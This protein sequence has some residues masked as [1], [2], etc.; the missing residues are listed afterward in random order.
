MEIDNDKDDKGFPQFCSNLFFFRSSYINKINW[1]VTKWYI[2]KYDKKYERKTGTIKMGDVK[3]LPTNTKRNLCYPLSSI[4]SISY[5]SIQ[6]YV[7]ESIHSA[8]K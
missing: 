1:G 8:H 7:F 4:I 3:G 5:K 2:A 6:W